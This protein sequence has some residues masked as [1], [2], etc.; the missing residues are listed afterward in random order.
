M[1]A[2]NFLHDIFERA[3]V[4]PMGRLTRGE[5][6]RLIRSLDNELER[7]WVENELRRAELMPPTEDDT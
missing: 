5:H 7:F 6:R 4:R 2:Y 3:G 1:L